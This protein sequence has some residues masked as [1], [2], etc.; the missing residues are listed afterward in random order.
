[1]AKSIR[2]TRKSRGRPKT[3]GAGMQIGMRWQQ[4][5]LDAVDT[6][7]A[8]Q[9]DKPTRPEAIRRLV[10]LGLASAQPAKPRSKKAASK[11]SELA[12][13]TIDHIADQSAPTEEREKRKRRLLK[14]PAEFRDL[15]ADLPKAKTKD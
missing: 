6:W 1:M 7:A 2:G 5:T 13:D 11:A 12:A 15:R 10:E 4:S 14:G 3:T 9:D 8:K